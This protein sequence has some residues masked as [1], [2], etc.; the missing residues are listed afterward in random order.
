MAGK[1]WQK[2]LQNAGFFADKVPGPSREPALTRALL[3]DTSSIS[4]D[5]SSGSARGRTPRSHGSHPAKV[6]CCPPLSSRQPLDVLLPQHLYCDDGSVC[7]ALPQKEVVKLPAE[8]PE[9]IMMENR[10]ESWGKIK[11][12]GWKSTPWLSCP[13]SEASF[14]HASLHM[15]ADAHKSKQN[16]LLS[17][18]GSAYT[19]VRMQPFEASYTQQGKR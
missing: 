1:S 15:C 9:L 17:V 19:E 7:L 13:E 2:V 11:D 10:F 14:G 6:R 4:S 12:A 16:S 5:T 8:S 3:T 18:S